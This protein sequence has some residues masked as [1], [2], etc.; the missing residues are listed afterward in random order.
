MLLVC[1]MGF[2]R[3]VPLSAGMASACLR[4]ACM[5]QSRVLVCLSH[6]CAGDVPAHCTA[7]GCRARMNGQH[8][9]DTKER[10]KQKQRCAKGS[11]EPAECVLCMAVQCSL[12]ARAVFTCVC[13]LRLQS[14]IPFCGCV[15][16]CVAGRHGLCW[17]KAWRCG[18]STAHA[19][20]C[21]LLL[22][23]FEVQQA[24]F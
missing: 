15:G 7:C 21:P 12:P 23:P 3:Q 6:M 2:R 13:C 19:C 4:L 8:R 20:F 1:L 9:R 5:S 22:C 24:C 17:S 16:C 18:R 10:A 11:L 14:C